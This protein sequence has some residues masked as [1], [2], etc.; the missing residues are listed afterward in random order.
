MDEQGKN[1]RV[2]KKPKK[3]LTGWDRAI[4]DAK[5]RIKRLKFT[6]EVYREHK[7]AG[8]VWPGDKSAT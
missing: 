7:K 3:V 4:A 5:E 1:S 8:E 6:I 2:S